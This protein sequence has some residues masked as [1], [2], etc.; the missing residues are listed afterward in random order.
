MVAPPFPFPMAPPDPMMGGMPPMPSPM[1]MPMPGPMGGMSDPMMGMPPPGMAGPMLPAVPQADPF[2]MM[3]PGPAL[4]PKM[5]MDLLGDLLG[6][7]PLPRH[8]DR[9]QEPPKPTAAEMLSKASQDRNQ[10]IALNRRFQDDLA[11][12]RMESVGVYDDFDE[13]VDLPFRDDALA[14]EDQMIASL[15]GTIPP[16]FESPK[17]RLADAD[18]SQAKEDFLAYLHEEHRRQHE[19]AGFSDLD[20]ELTKTI[21]RYGRICTRNMCAFQ[22]QPGHAPFFMRAIDPAIVYPTF[23]GNRGL[24]V[25]TLIYTQR[26][27]DLIGDH[28]TDGELEKKLFKGTMKNTKRN[29]AY[30]WDDEIEV[31][32]YW[33]CKW[34]G[35]FAAGELVKGPLA[36]DY[37]EPPFVYTHASYG[38]PGYTRTPEQR[39]ILDAQGLTITPSQADL[40]RR[41]MS[42]FSTRFTNHA[43][44]E[45]M[46][47][48]LQ[49]AFRMWKQE[50]L[51]V[52]QDDEVYG[53]GTPKISRASG[54]INTIRRDHEQMVP[55]PDP[56]LPPTLG[57]LMAAVNEGAARAGLSPAEY[58]MT[59]SAQQSGYA[60]AGLSE[61]GKHK[62][63]PVIKTKQS[64]HAAVGEQ[65]LRFYRDWGHL[66][67]DEGEKGMIAFPKSMPDRTKGGESMWEVTPE[68]IDR[69]G[70][71]VTC[72]LVETPDISSLS[73]MANAFGLLGQQGAMSRRE[74]IR[75]LGLPG[76]RNPEQTMREVDIE[77][78]REMPEFKLASLLKYVVEEMDEPDLADF[79]MAQIA[80]GK[81][82]EQGAMA[83][84]PGPP[85]GSGGP[86]GPPPGGPASVPGM[87]LPGMGQPPGTE[88]GRPPMGPMNQGPP[89]EL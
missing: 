7:Q 70:T 64:H 35:L 32:E 3:G 23:A 61:N 81:A 1:G 18:E 48:K 76:S 47:G 84:P 52:A 67:G 25:V 59:P 24:I 17:R 69:T 36:H 15:V 26:V 37:G 33:D 20:I 50:P 41:G 85:M 60:I 9:W 53:K 88:G 56:Q 27:A 58:G 8:R 2:S 42:H 75:L 54:A 34:F 22:G 44:R 68:M 45:A 31:T 89:N 63:S 38:D 79:I 57:P 43:Q 39:N 80:K 74:K 66:L 71:Q 16:T 11:R 49:T 55:P 78:L 82:K 29:R 65:R 28:D 40:S 13:D 14:V 77:G 6:P 21:T 87:S 12:I 83:P 46:L 5:L 73:A 10:L 62:L 30:D 51:Y 72:A 86:Q 4:D 19:R